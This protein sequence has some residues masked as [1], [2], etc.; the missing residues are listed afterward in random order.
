MPFPRSAHDST[1]GLLYFARMIH[2]MQLVREG[3]L[4]PDYLPMIGEGFDGRICRFLKLPYPLIRDRAAE[5]GSN[6][7][8][9]EW[10]FQQSHRP[11]EE[12]ILVWNKYASKT[13]WRDEDTGAT[14]RLE[15]QKIA[16]GLAN[17]PDICTFFDF[18]DY[19]E[20]RRS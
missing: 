9:L 19:D 7:E 8:I 3:T 10:C 17:R 5:G 20:G 11:T 16:A 1:L 14:G 6:E 4:P 13:G 2:K 18:Y 15:T 12:E